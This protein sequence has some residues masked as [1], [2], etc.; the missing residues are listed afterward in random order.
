M[1]TVDRF[2]TIGLNPLFRLINVGIKTRSMSL[3]APYFDSFQL[4]PIDYVDQINEVNMNGQ[5]A[6]ALIECWDE[7]CSSNETQIAVGTGFII[8]DEKRHLLVTAHHIID[9]FRK[10]INKLA[11]R[12]HFADR[13]SSQP[14]MLTRELYNI[15]WES[16]EKHMDAIIFELREKC[17]N[18]MRADGC[19]FLSTSEPRPFLAIT[20]FQYPVHHSENTVARHLSCSYGRVIQVRAPSVFYLVGSGPAS[21][22]GPIINNSNSTV[23][24]VHLGHCIDPANGRDKLVRLG[25]SI[26]SIIAE[27]R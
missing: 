16:D 1:Y 25:S 11:F 23:I 3:V 19:R 18:T 12:I 20:L 26:I 9:Q 27:Y 24:G 22:G 14:I 7:S 4:N 6:T 10:P 15:V 2:N 21:S 13:P 5:C 8:E 17:V